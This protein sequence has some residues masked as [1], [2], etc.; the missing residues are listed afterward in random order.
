MSN[1]NLLQVNSDAKTSKG[2]KRGYM[3]GILYLAPATE[4]SEAAQMPVNL[5]PFAT[6]GCAKACLYTAGRG[7]MDSVQTARINKTLRYLNDREAF[8]R[9]LNFSV[10]ALIRKAEREGK[11]PVVRL[12]GTSDLP[13]EKYRVPVDAETLE[14]L[15]NTKADLSRPQK[16]ML[17]MDVWGDVQFYDYTKNPH[18]AAKDLP[19]NYHLT[20]SLAESNREDAERAL[21]NGLNVAAVFRSKPFPSRF[22]DR[23]VIDGDETDLRF[24]DPSGV[25]VG[26]SAKGEAKND[27][28]GF[29][30]D[31]PVL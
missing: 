23:P 6:E 25:I 19:T 4:A 5:C 7:R 14:P 18:R 22:M 11:I 2:L 8:R 15:T 27:T 13:W 16:T 31:I 28:T 9:D 26:L 30:Q 3:T 21:S 20:F 1:K 10:G 17:L 12:N 29:V 24:L